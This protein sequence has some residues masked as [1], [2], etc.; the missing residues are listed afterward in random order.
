MKIII[1]G[2]GDVG[3]HL[4]KM[5]SNENHDIVVIDPDESKLRGVDNLDLITINGS[6]TSFKTLKDA[7]VKKADLLIS[8]TQSEDTNL[9]A[10]MLAKKLGA[11]R[12]V[13]R[14]NNKEYLFAGNK[15]FFQSLGVDYLIYPQNIAVNELVNLVSQTG[16]VDIFDFSG[17]MLSLFVI[18]IE[19]DSP[20]INQT[21]YELTQNNDNLEYRAVAITRQTKTIIPR[22]IDKFEPNDLI[23]VISSQDGLKQLNKITG[24]E[25]VTVKNVMILGGS[26]I[27]IGTASQLENK[28]NVK[29]IEQDK[30]KC[31]KLASVLNNTLIINGDGRNMDLL[32]EEGLQN[33][34]AFIS[35]TDNSE[36]NIL[37]CLLAKR[38]GVKRTITEIENIDYINI[39]EN[40]GI[41]TIINKKLITAGRIFRFTRSAQ[42]ADIKCLTGSDAE[43]VEFIAQPGSKVTK[44]HIKDIGLP[45]DS[46]IG[47]VVRGKNS[48]IATGDLKVEPNDRVVVFVLPSSFYK[49][50]KFFN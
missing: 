2:A 13:A 45:K 23:Y 8:V 36:T 5:L 46:I 4:A 47:G 22:G 40:M 7:N 27:G 33:M 10:S 43:I 50:E 48:Y 20:L 21:L 39:A 38:M 31:F 37:S 28:Y 3:T 15:D 34:D 44:S 12:T 1:A 11:A 41:D 18:K 49:L 6:A 25:T 14:I 17:G 24:K 35:V 42:V 30:D 29:L 16:T 9:T 19:E 32:S 26:R